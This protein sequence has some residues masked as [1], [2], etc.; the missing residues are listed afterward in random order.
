[1]KRN[2]LIALNI[3]LL[4]IF[5]AELIL[6]TP[7]IF[8][9]QP[10]VGNMEKALPITPPS[11]TPSPTTNIEAFAPPELPKNHEWTKTEPND[12]DSI[13]NTNREE[14]IFADDKGIT[15]A[16][17]EWE[18]I[19]SDKTSDLDEYQDTLQKAG[20]QNSIDHNG[21][22]L[23]AVAAD[24]PTGGVWGYM[25]VAN[26]NIRVIIVSLRTISKT[27]GK[28]VYPCPCDYEYRVFVSEIVP[29]KKLIPEKN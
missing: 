13:Y 3:L 5:T 16:G 17:E 26:E 4:L 12:Q 27:T 20:W 7:H 23:S 21:Y 11:T 28:T 9:L 6:I 8:K 14:I 24:G 22:N 18:T 25:K 10:E 19:S 15:I 29:I 1:M 2:L